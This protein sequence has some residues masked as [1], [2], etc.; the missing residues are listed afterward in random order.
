M[1]PS[2]LLMSPGPG[3]RQ[4]TFKDHYKKGGGPRGGRK[5]NNAA[6]RA[7]RERQKTVRKQS[8]ALVH[9]PR[10]GETIRVHQAHG[11]SATS[12]E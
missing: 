12:G 3:K 1:G 2:V 8:H 5:F 7:R 6:V 10:T 9:N 4:G 11:I